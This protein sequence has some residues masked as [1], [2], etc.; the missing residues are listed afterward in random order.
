MTNN[1]PNKIRF[2]FYIDPALHRRAKVAAAM[3]NKSLSD[4]I[5]EMINAEID[6]AEKEGQRQWN[7]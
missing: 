1:T 5:N 3:Q 2:T 7:A 6:K 4:L